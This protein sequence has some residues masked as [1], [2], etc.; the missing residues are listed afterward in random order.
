MNNLVE[1]WKRHSN[2]EK[3]EVSSFG[4][5]RSV[6]GHYYKSYLINS[7]Y[8]Q[9]QFRMNK[10][11]VHKSVHR[12]VAQVFIP[13]PD[14]L[15]EVNHKDCDKTNNKVENL[16]WCTSSYNKQYREKFGISTTESQGHPLFAINL[17]TL[18]ISHFRSQWEASRELRIDQANINKVING[19]HNQTVGYWF[20]NDDSHAVDVV[21][22]KLHDI[23]KTGLKIKH[24]AVN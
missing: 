7:G 19:K 23:G 14:N 4:R 5:V 16:E 21:K 22:S 10:K 24:R 12:L 8:L 15:P 20:V 2:I 11:H 18:E 17:T 9:I 1:S 6:N 13:N 3:L